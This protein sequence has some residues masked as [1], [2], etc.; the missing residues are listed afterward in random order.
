MNEQFD[1]I[2]IGSGT[3]MFAPPTAAHS[4]QSLLRPTEGRHAKRNC[5]AF[6]RVVPGPGATIGQ[7]LSYGSIAAWHAAGLL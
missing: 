7:W 5:A 6:S 4:G 3:G 1:V 2:V